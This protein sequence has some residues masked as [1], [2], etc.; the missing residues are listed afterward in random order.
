MKNYKPYPVND[1]AK[2]YRA[3]KPPIDRPLFSAKRRPESRDK[4]AQPQEKVERPISQQ[5][6][7]QQQQPQPLSVNLSFNKNHATPFTPETSHRSPNYLVFKP[8]YSAPVVQYNYVQPQSF[9]Q[10]Q[11]SYRQSHYAKE[12]R[13]TAA[14]AASAIV[15]P[16]S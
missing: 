8:K 4:Y 1:I 11:S 7:Q 13:A 3:S 6:Q 14:T 9:V 12:K 16:V 10:P 2:Y 5:Q 15:D